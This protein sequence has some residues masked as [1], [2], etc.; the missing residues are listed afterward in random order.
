MV[1]TCP[2]TNGIVTLVLP[3]FIVFCDDRAAVG[4]VGRGGAAK[5]T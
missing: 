2:Q 5:V 4:D 1:A 3:T